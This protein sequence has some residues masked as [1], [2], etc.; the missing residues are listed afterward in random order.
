M[1]ES[2]HGLR[3]IS[4]QSGASVAFK[5]KRTLNGRQDWMVQSRMTHRGL[6]VE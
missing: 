3:V 5:V 6:G 2:T 1:H 4:L